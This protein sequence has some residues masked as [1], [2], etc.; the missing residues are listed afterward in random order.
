MRKKNFC[1]KILFSPL[2]IFY[3]ANERFRFGFFS[4]CKVQSLLFQQF[5]PLG[6]MR[7][8]CFWYFVPM[9]F[10]Y[11]AGFFSLCGAAGA[12]KSFLNCVRYNPPFPCPRKGGQACA[13]PSVIAKCAIGLFLNP[14][15]IWCR[16]HSALSLQFVDTLLLY[17]DGPL[18]IPPGS[19]ERITIAVG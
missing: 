4:P 14:R 3:T 11:L 1:A 16:I 12:L 13:F 10:C 18:N 5:A 17:E 6:A 2:R 15:R 8:C 7:S 19:A 9:N